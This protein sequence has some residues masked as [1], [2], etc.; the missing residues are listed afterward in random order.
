MLN[1]PFGINGL[2]ISAFVCNLLDTQLTKYICL[3]HI[4]LD[5]YIFIYI[6]YPIQGHQHPLFVYTTTYT[7][8]WDGLGY[9]YIYGM[10][11]DIYIFAYVYMG[12]IWDGLGSEITGWALG[13]VRVGN[14]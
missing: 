3:L 11:K 2:R 12:Y 14:V 8:I 13:S 5:I 4:D 9:I 10:V 7:Y 6:V 1:A